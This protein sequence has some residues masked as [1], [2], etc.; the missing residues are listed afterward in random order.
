MAIYAGLDL[1]ST[2]GKV[3]LINDDGRI[4]GWSIVRSMGGPEKTASEAR[5]KALEMAGLPPETKFDYLVAT[6]YGRNN[7]L[8]KDE[9]ISEISCHALGAHTLVPEVRTIIDIG[10]QDCKVISI[11]KTG[12]VMDFQMNDRCSA[13]TGRFFEVIAR[14]LGLSLTELSEQALKGTNPCNISKQC[15][16]FAESEVISLVNNSTPMPDIC[17]GVT[18]SIA[19]RIRGMVTKVGLTEQVALTGGCAQNKSLAKALEKAM[20]VK[21]AELPEHPQIIGALGAAR[22][23]REHALSGGAAKVQELPPAP[24]EVR[25]VKVIRPEVRKPAADIPKVENWD[26]VSVEDLMKMVSGS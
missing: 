2:T 23:A 26:K 11:N 16:V 24:A 18:E 10:G 3:V 19:R 4:L 17:A 9:D 5:E 13:G 6:G 22:F 14:V 1:G 20:N 21:L 12:R 8:A 25:T 7:F 15:S